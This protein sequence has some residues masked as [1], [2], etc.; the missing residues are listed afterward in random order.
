M[1]KI[2]FTFSDTIAGYVTTANKDT[3]TFG[4]KT[5]DGREF[6]IAITD[7]TYAEVIR[8][9]DEPFQ[10]PGGPLI[11]LL[12]PGRYLFAYGIFYPEGDDLK[13]EAK[14]LIFVC[15]LTDE[16][17][18]EAQDW[19]IRQIRSLA[20]FYYNAQFPDGNVDFNN[21]RTHLTLEGQKIESTRQET[22]TISRMIYGFASAYML[23]GED[24]Y[25]E[26]AQKGTD[27]L[28]EHMRAIDK[29]EDIV[30]WYHA[31]DVQGNT[32]RKILASEFG[33]DYDAIPAY[34][35]IYALAGP[36]QTYRVTGDPRILRDAEMTINLFNKF[37]LDPDKGGYF[38]HVDPVTFNP[39]AES[40]GKDRARK[41]WNSVGDH[42]P[43]YLIN[44]WLA[45]GEEKYA[46]FLAY[47]ADTIA[48]HF[49]DYENSPFVQER[50]FED[51][52]QDKTWGWQ[53]NRA[54]VGH[55]LKIAWN[56]MRI[57]HLRPSEKYTNLARKIAE[58]MPTVGM[59]R[60]RGGWY[61]VMERT[62]QPGQE[63]NRFVW[64]DRKAWWQQEQAILAYLILNGSL[65]DPEYLRLA[66]ES[67]S[68]YNAF[69]PDLDN[70][71]VYFNV[72]DNG[73]PYLMGTERLKGSHSMSGYHSFE[74][75]YLAA[76]YTNLLIWQQPMDLYFK[77]QP[78]SLK[79]NILRIQP[80]IL[81][82]GSIRIEG[83]WINGDLHRDFDADALTIKLPTIIEQHALENRPA[84][85]GNPSY[86]ATAKRELKIRV[87]IVPSGTLFDSR[88]EFRGSTAE[89]VLAGNLNEVALPTFKAQLDK[90]IAAQPKHV[91]LRL[92]NLQSIEKAPARALTFVTEKLTLDD[93]IYVIGANDQVKSVLQ[94]VEIWESLNV[95]EGVTAD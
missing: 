19:W 78:G 2:Q 4:L 81:P 89:L 76:V 72:F 53:Q 52:S 23:T 95:D 38:S 33:D 63:W 58:I 7:T 20:E 41:N 48:D 91:I 9:L 45:T 67:A 90:I 46:D 35:Q 32:E 14:H 57:H 29:D 42:A 8:N 50:Y 77:P 55:N 47:T 11:D 10:D 59:D 36:I 28:R 82:P 37:F 49:P 43:A 17:R 80:D 51:W 26:V 27:Y 22:D 68:F 18:F 71:G 15:Y 16:Y 85:A 13:F 44:L 40:L 62:T 31:M 79:D 39:R 94:A 84:W 70:G 74:L 65:K 3:Q 73:N 93:S 86:A 64:H 92:E 88:L 12:S 75:C 1:N 66:R 87:R 6:E 61:D 56:L 30:Y 60:Q 69:F 54:V 24:R 34:E 21:Y 83:V 5:S 25:L